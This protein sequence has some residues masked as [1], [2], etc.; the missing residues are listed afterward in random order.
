MLILI[1]YYFDVIVTHS[2]EMNTQE[3]EAQLMQ[4]IRDKFGNLKAWAETKYGVDKC[5]QYHGEVD[6]L[7]ADYPT[8]LVLTEDV[9]RPALQQGKL[10]ALIKAKFADEAGIVLTDEDAAHVSR[11][12]HML[13]DLM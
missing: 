5:Q 10:V 2:N 11:Y 6:K 8:L 3:E 9:F 1:K 12:F 4:Y 7:L 13:C